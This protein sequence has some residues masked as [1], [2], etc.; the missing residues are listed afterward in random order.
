MSGVG[1][2]IALSLMQALLMLPATQH[3]YIPSPAPT[4]EPRPVLPAGPSGSGWLSA[5]GLS[6]FPAV[7]HFDELVVR[8]ISNNSPSDKSS[9][10]CLLS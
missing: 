6:L 8:L 2:Q 10:P 1:D 3:D 4:V 5:R 9:A 7:L